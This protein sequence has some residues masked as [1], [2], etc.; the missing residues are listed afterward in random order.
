MNVHARHTPVDLGDELERMV[1]RMVREGLYADREEVLRAG[2]VALHERDTAV[3]GPADGPDLG[4]PD[5]ALRRGIADADAG[6]VKPADEVFDRLIAKYAAM[7]R[8]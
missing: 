2:V 1:A 5:A 4:D 6:R 8:G 3:S 7:P